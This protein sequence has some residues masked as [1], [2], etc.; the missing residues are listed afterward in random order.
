MKQTMNP[1][2]EMP[3]N[4]KDALDC[5]SMSTNN[6]RIAL[7][8]FKIHRYVLAGFNTIVP[9]PIENPNAAIAPNVFGFF[10]MPGILVPGE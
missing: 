8:T 5:E 9:R 10:A 1:T 7:M 2:T 6:V 3:V 4:N